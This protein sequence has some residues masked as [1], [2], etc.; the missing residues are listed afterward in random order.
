MIKKLLAIIVLVMVASLSIAGCTSSTNSNQA[1]SNASQ[2]ASSAAAT[3][4]IYDFCFS[5]R[6]SNA[7]GYTVAFYRSYTHTYAN[8]N[9]DA[10][11]SDVDSSVDGLHGGTSVLAYI[12]NNESGRARTTDSSEILGQCVRRNEPV[13]R[14]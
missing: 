12:A 9:S 8:A 6:I 13:R 5:V 4:A 3:T 14:C 2:A 11:H 7:F 1:A 10:A